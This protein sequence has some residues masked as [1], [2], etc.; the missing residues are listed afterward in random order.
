MVSVY[1]LTVEYRQNPLGIDEVQPR[2]SWKLRGDLPNTCQQSYRI[3]VSGEHMHWDSGKVESDRS[4]LVEYIG[5][6]LAPRTRYHWEVTV[7]TSAGETACGN[8]WLKRA[9]WMAVFL[10]SMH[11]GSPI[12]YPRRILSALY[13]PAVFPLPSPLS[14]RG[15]MPARWA[16][17]RR[18]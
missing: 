10:K 7:W 15:G 8:A 5:P 9:C 12:P 14:G 6:A 16:C 1:D 13:S 18:S 2:F 17:M 4:V 3:V 11:R